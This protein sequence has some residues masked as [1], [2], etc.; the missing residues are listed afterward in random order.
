MKYLFKISGFY[1]FTLLFAFNSD[2]QSIIDSIFSIREVSVIS[3][4]PLKERGLIKTTIDNSVIHSSAYNDLTNLL[5]QHSPLYIKTYG[6]GSLATASFRGMSA[7]HTRVDWNGIHLNN[8]MPGQVDFSLIP[9]FFADEISL[10]YGGSSLYEGSGALGGSVI[11]NTIPVWADTIGIS[12]VHKSG[13]FGSNNTLADIRG[14][15]ESIQSRI[16]IFREK[17]NNDFLF[18]NNMNGDWDFQKQENA[19]YIK[20]GVLHELY[21][22]TTKDDIFS[23]NTWFQKADRNFPL[24]MSYDGGGRDENQQDMD[25]R[26]S[27]QWKKYQSRLYSETLIGLNYSDVEYY[28]GEN[29]LGG[30]I[31]HFDTENS[32]YSIIAKNKIEFKLK[33]DL[34]FRNLLDFCHHDVSSFDRKSL[35]GYENTRTSLGNTISIHKKISEKISGYGLLRTEL[36]DWEFIPLMPSLGIEINPIQDK[37]LRFK[38]N[39]S[40]NF[41]LPGLNDLYWIPGGNINLK[42]E[43]G[44]SSDFSV[45]YKEQILGS[46]AIDSRLSIYYSLID[47]WIIWR[48]GEYGYWTAEN[49]RKVASRG[50]EYQF[51]ADYALEDFRTT[52]YMNYSFTKA[53]NLENNNLNADIEGKQLIYVPVYKGN[54]ILRLAMRSNYFSYNFS[55]T[56]RRYTTTSNEE[57]RN[58]LP[59]YVLHGFNIGREFNVNRLSADL[60]VRVNNLLGLDYQAILERAMPGRNYQLTLN[61]RF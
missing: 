11:L 53:T 26:L 25:F 12:L 30:D 33:T 47:D 39:L 49:I 4:T 61:L 14:G 46:I 35:A 32:F 21:F 52:L 44:Y 27:L 15:N 2:A 54:S 5:S 22:R 41:H 40:R 13:S 9:L 42:P 59:A 38:V 51:S 60:N 45:E 28:A 43:K 8:P 17:S 50:A 58:S 31:V 29:N 34:I 16:R 55:Y 20:S 6:Q 23:V 3:E 48:P 1:I 7:S 37:D 19:E 36:S 18:Y 56:G 10:L 24:I 57:S